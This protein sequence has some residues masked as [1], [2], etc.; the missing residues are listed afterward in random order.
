MKYSRSEIIILIENLINDEPSLRAWDDLVSV[1]H[2]DPYTDY[3]ARELLKIQKDYSDRAN[4]RLISDK[5]I[6]KLREILNRLR[7]VEGEE[8]PARTTSDLRLK[9]SQK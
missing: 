3:W 8:L 2:K 7:S 4:G 5:G 6:I 1:N 9:P